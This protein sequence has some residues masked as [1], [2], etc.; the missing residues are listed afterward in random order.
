M[1]ALLKTTAGLVP[2][3]MFVLKKVKRLSFTPQFEFGLF[4]LCQENKKLVEAQLLFFK[5]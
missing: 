1:Q 2:S 4:F 3:L 5:F